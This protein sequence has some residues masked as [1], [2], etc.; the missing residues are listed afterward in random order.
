MDFVVQKV[1]KDYKHQERFWRVLV[2]L[3]QLLDVPR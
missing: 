2:E 3:E 1:D